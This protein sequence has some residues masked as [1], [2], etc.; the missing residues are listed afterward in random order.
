VFCDHGALS[1]CDPAV[2]VAECARLLRA[3]GRLVFCHSTPL[4]Y[5][6]WDTDTHRQT[7]RLQERWR[8]RW[9]FDSGEGTID[10]VWSY[11]AWIRV[12]REHGLVVDDLI[13]LRPPKGATST[14]TEFVPYDWARR[15][16][17]EQIW[18]ARKE[19]AGGGAASGART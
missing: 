18:C 10:F 13:E 19:P 12:L 17:A 11:G 3:G 15:W 1:F 2:A 5:L 9:V 16:P 14:Y 4:L 6:T 7:R 8:D